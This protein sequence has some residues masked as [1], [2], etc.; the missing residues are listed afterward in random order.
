MAMLGAFSAT[1]RNLSLAGSAG[2]GMG[3]VGA[4]HAVR[5]AVAR[6]GLVDQAQVGGAAGRAA[7]ADAL[8]HGH[9]SGMKFHLG[10]VTE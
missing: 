2:E 7:L 8:G 6:G 10:P 9:N 5:A 3:H 1:T 4:A